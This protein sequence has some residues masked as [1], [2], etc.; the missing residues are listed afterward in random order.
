MGSNSQVV[1]SGI[2]EGVSDVVAF[3]LRSHTL[4]SNQARSPIKLEPCAFVLWTASKIAALYS[5]FGVGAGT[6]VQK[7]FYE[8]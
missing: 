1:R 2:V 7:I 8:V 5:P 3:K 6:D 4:V